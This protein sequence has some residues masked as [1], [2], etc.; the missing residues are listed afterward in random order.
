MIRDHRFHLLQFPMMFVGLI[1]QLSLLTGMFEEF[2]YQWLPGSGMIGEYRFHPQ[3][4]LRNS[5]GHQYLTQQRQHL[6]AI[7]RHLSRVDQVYYRHQSPLRPEYRSMQ[8]LKKAK[9]YL[10][11]PRLHLSQSR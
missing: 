4:C 2:Q 9:G 1:Y 10:C 3:L 6:F 7:D 8:K 11:Q 5:Q